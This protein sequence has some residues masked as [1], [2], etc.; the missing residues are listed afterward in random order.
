MVKGKQVTNVIPCGLAALA[1]ARTS[2][3]L[4][5]LMLS[6]GVPNRTAWRFGT[7]AKMSPRSLDLV[8][9]HAIS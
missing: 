5:I 2:L 1:N 9:L 7:A 4:T 6:T 3:W 8:I